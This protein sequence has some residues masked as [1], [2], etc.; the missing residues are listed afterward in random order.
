MPLINFENES[1]NFRH[2]AND[3]ETAIKEAKIKTIK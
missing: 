2:K 3:S 1:P